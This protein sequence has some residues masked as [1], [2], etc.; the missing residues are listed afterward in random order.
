MKVFMVTSG[1]YSDYT[2]EGI[3]STIDKAKAYM[4]YESRNTRY[5]KYND[6][7]EIEVDNVYNFSIRDGY[8]CYYGNMD[9]DGNIDDHGIT[10]FSITDPTDNHMFENSYRIEYDKSMTF[11]IKT[12][13]EEH[14]IKIA[15]DKRAELIASNQWNPGKDI[16]F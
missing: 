2:V 16:Y 3:F 15:N 6:I 11:E 9:E 14:A 10:S 7:V 4:D 12:V 13:S 5:S 8:K 1:R